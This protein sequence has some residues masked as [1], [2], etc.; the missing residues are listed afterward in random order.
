MLQSGA[1]RAGCASVRECTLS[2][3][4]HSDMGSAKPV[5]E[6]EP[7]DL[8]SEGAVVGRL[9]L[10]RNRVRW[11]VMNGH[12]Q[13]GVTADRSSGGVTR[14]SVEREEA[15]RRHATVAQRVRRILRY[16]FFWMP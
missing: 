11:L 3:R 4:H 8:L 7:S 15:W 1:K 9:G 14:Q 10:S 16:G 13:R 6:V 2:D 12:L 5:E